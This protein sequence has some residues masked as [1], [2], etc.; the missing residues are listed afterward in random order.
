MASRSNWFL[1]FLADLLNIPVERPQLTETTALG[2]ACLAGVQLGVFDSLTD[3]QKYWQRDA[4]FTPR[5]SAGSALYLAC[6]SLSGYVTGLVIE[7][8]GGQLMA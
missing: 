1:Q 6:D 2:A 4:L 8:N 3:I 7:V 5:L